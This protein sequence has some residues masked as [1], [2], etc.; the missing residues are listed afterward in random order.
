MKRF[1]SAPLFVL[2]VVLSA[3]SPAIA[4][5]VAHHGNTVDAEGIAESCISCHDGSIAGNVSFCTVKC[6]FSTPH[7]IM[8]RYPPMGKKASFFA[9]AAEVTA[10]G[11]RIVNGKVT[12]VSCHNLKNAARYH[13]VQDERGRLCVICHIKEVG[14]GSH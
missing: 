7:A 1:S 8:K 14:G 12:C 3:A 6:D 13:L 9:S 10:K 11:V 2:L 5:R 4:D